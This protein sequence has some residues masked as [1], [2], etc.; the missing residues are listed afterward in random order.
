MMPDPRWDAL[1]VSAAPLL[2]LTAAIALL[3]YVFGGR[4]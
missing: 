1:F 3:L 4:W 2:L